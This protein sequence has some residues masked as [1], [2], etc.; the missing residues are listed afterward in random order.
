M[1]PMNQGEIANP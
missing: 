1:T